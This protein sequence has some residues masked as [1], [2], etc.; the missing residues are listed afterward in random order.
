MLSRHLSTPLRRALA[1]TAFFAIGAAVLSLTWGAVDPDTHWWSLV[2]VAPVIGMLTYLQAS[3][4]EGALAA[5]FLALGGGGLLF[6]IAV[7]VSGTWPVTRAD[8]PWIALILTFPL[9]CLGIGIQKWRRV[10][11]TRLS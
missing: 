6:W 9:V 1:S 11:R 5:F 4:R 3:G 8:L 7:L 10:Q 2:A